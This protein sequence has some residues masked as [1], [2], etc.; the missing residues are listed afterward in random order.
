[1]GS[2]MVTR[3]GRDGRRTW[4]WAGHWWW[5]T[6]VE[7]DIAYLGVGLLRPCTGNLLSGGQ[8]GRLS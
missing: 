8:R 5:R 7:V 6:L 4:R 3:V 1:M 2:D